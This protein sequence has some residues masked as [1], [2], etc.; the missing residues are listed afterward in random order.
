MTIQFNGDVR[1]VYAANLHAL[2]QELGLAGARL[3]TA[4]NG[5]FVPATARHDFPIAS[6]DRVEALAPMQ[7]G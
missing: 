5:R 3:A 7:G 1:D 2:L 6:G 4:V